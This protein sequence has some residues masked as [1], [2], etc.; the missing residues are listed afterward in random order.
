MIDHS[1]AA[2]RIQEKVAAILAQVPWQAWVAIVRKEAEWQNM[3]GFLPAYGFGR[4]ATLMLAAG[5]NDYQLKGKAEIAYW[6]ELKR[7]LNN[8]SVPGSTAELLRILVPFYE[9][10]KN[11]RRKIEVLEQF[12]KS[13]LAETL[14]DASPSTVAA[15][16]LSIWNTLAAALTQET[17]EKQILF[18]MKCLGLSLMIAGE[19]GF[20]FNPI[21]IPADSRLRKLTKRLKIPVD[22]QEA[23]RKW[24][25]EILTLLQKNHRQLSM[26]H[27]DSLLWQISPLEGSR[28]LDYFAELGVPHVGSELQKLF[29]KI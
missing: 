19:E 6:P 4:F 26:I 8:G 9:T 24:W 18:A 16:F 23:M 1:D 3:A 22:G 14:W 20:D 10:E 5:L 25:R 2:G 21:P 7:L 17:E 13:R 27:L 29:G 15:E 11:S 28:L 12:L